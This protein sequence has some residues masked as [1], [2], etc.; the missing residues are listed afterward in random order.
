LSIKKTTNLEKKF[1][2]SN[3][4]RRLRKFKDI[5]VS[6]L[7]HF[8]NINKNNLRKYETN[9]L[10]PALDNLRILADYFGISLDFLLLWDK[11]KYPR[12]ILLFSLAK[13]IDAMDQVKRFQ[14]ES[15]ATSLIGGKKI[16]IEFEI[17]LDEF[18]PKLTVNINENIKILRTHKNILQREVAEY[19]GIH[20]KAFTPYE[21][22]SIPPAPK[23]I[24]MAEFLNVSIHSLATG[25]KLN[26][27][28]NSK[29]LLRIIFLADRLL[30]LEDKKILIRLMQRIIED[31]DQKSS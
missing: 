15:T 1:H 5:T 10:L 20:P 7:Y 17:K 6:D 29:Q 13:K 9:Y 24:K 12:N 23:L 3:N 21:R 27:E 4:L 11:T 25:I 8:T 30:N 18:Y 26:Y 19:I 22:K 2:I 16:D 31:S 28:F 14:I